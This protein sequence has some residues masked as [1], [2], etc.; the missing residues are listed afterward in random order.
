MPDGSSSAA[1]VMR[2]GPRSFRKSD[3]RV[4]RPGVDD[5]V[6]EFSVGLG[7][8]S[9]P[10]LRRSADSLTCRRI[11]RRK[12]ALPLMPIDGE[13]SRCSVGKLQG[14]LSGKAELAPT[15]G[16]EI[17]VAMPP[18]R[19]RSP[20]YA[21]GT[22]EWLELIPFVT[23]PVLLRVFRRSVGSDSARPME[24]NP[25]CA[26][27]SLLW[28]LRDYRERPVLLCETAARRLLHVRDRYK[29]GAALQPTRDA[30]RDMI[31]P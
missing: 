13:R 4:D 7:G 25:L 15:A 9:H 27:P 3:R 6:R 18:S 28:P 22:A 2:P 17:Q 14:P 1:P 5:R 20:W 30:D 23:K 12:G 19:C 11:T 31:C 8:T 16:Q 24:T 26:C 29:N 21:S 10:N